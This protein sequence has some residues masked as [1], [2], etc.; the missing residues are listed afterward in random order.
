MTE[1][2]TLT[3]EQRRVKEKCIALRGFWLPQDDLLQADPAFL[4]HYLDLSA[5]PK[6]VL[7]PKL[8]HLI[9][10]AIDCSV[11]HLHVPAARAHVRMAM[12]DHGATFRE[13]LQV[14]ELASTIGIHSAVD[15]VRILGEE[16]DGETSEPGAGSLD[17]RERGLLGSWADPAEGMAR[18]D[19]EWAD[20]ALAYWTH[21]IEHGPLDRV[22]VE[23]VSIA[24]CVAS[25]YLNE[26]A[27]R[28]HVRNALAHGAEPREIVA[29][30]EVASVLGMHTASDTV[31]A[32]VE[33][34]A[35][36]GT[37]PDSIDRPEA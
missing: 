33:E 34:A 16:L 9:H 22:E 13:V 30:I 3:D 18:F 15:G 27:T 32:L 23:L 1:D 5:H 14:V 11:T 2:R 29:A 37:L 6:D 35:A 7:G 31:P 8:K 28:R 4:E 24:V 25:T 36:C 12:E 10:V 20:Y 21:P 19:Q 26:E 17:S